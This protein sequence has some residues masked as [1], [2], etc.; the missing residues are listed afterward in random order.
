MRIA[1]I[2]LLLTATIGSSDMNNRKR[3]SWAD[4]PRVG[5]S[6]PGLPEH[7]ARRDASFG[8][9]QKWGEEHGE[10]IEGLTNERV[11]TTEIRNFQPKE[12][13]KDPKDGTMYVRAFDLDEE[14]DDAVGLSLM[15]PEHG[16]ED[17]PEDERRSLEE[18]RSQPTKMVSGPPSWLNSPPKGFKVVKAQAKDAQMAIDKAKV[19]QPRPWAG[20]PSGSYF[21]KS[22]DG[23]TGY[24]LVPV[25]QQ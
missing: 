25:K 24:A 3:P 8:A 19:G 9:Q 17:T 16:F 14:V 18:V 7:E 23:Y 6:R 12:F 15:Q 20:Q 21:E 4:D 1:A 13:W 11:K 10:V 2:L 22:G 5:K